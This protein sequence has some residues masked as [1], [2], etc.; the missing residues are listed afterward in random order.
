M[1][2]FIN[3]HTLHDPIAADLDRAIR[4][5][6]SRGVFL[7]GPEVEEF[8]A[9]WAAYCAQ[10][11][12]VACASG[13]DALM[14]AARVFGGDRLAVAAN[15]CRFSEVGLSR[16][17]EE[18]S[19]MDVDEHGHCDSQHIVPVLLYGR[20]WHPYSEHSQVMFDA[21]QAHG[22][23]PHWNALVAWSGY[24]TKNLGAFG[25]CGWVT[26]CCE[27]QAVKMRAMAAAHHSRMS[28]MNAAILR[29]KLHH[30]EQ[31]NA[32]RLRLAEVYWNELPSWVEPVCR[33]G[34]PS[35]HHIFAVLVDHRDA[36]QQ[37]LAA[38]EIQTKI[39]YPEPLAPLP[40]AIRWCERILSLP[41][42][43]GMTPEQVRTVCD[44]I[45]VFHA[46]SA[47]PRGAA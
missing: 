4:R 32:D 30:L 24:P 23:K 38:H 12:C 6:A 11:F 7:N 37:H 22:W 15:T 10:R 31:W 19:F 36:L 17:C 16:G 9:A 28:E 21:C 27:K 18:V 40:G 25:D 47:I 13:T 20:Q 26:T 33:P 43:V 2:P 42:W 45:K 44:S 14:L 1:I 46:D 39:H 29:T 35:N 5:V 3:L 41:L 34:E 8:E